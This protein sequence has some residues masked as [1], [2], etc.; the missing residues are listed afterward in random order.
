MPRKIY[1]LFEKLE[2]LIIQLFDMENSMVTFL[3][4]MYSQN[5][6][7]KQQESKLQKNDQEN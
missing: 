7:N 2:L 4:K 5:G 1:I 6:D 3:I